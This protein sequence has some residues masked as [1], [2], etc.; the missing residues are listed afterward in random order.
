MG[1]RG[2]DP[3]SIRTDHSRPLLHS[4]S[5]GMRMTAQLGAR[6]RLIVFC[7]IAALAAHAPLRADN[8]TAGAVQQATAVSPAPPAGT[9]PGPKVKFEQRQTV[10]GDR[11][12]QRLGMQLNVTTKIVQSGQV[13]HQSANEIRSQQQRT[14]DVLEAV[15]GRAVKARVLFDVAR[16]QTPDSETPTELVASPTQGKS[17]LVTRQ[18][19]KLVVTDADGAIPPLAEFTL[20]SEAL[21]GVGRPNPL[22]VVLAG[23]EVAIGQ[24]M[25]VPRDL[26]KSLLGLGGP[27]LADVHKFELT[28]DRLAAPAEAGAPP[29]AVFRVTIEVKP[30]DAGGLAVI[31][32][33]EMAVEPTTCRLTSVDLAGPVHVSTIERTELGFYQYAMDGELRVATRAQFGSATK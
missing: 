11:V 25:F 6:P 13:A 27:E 23:R 22:A 8:T 3:K 5:G 15:D 30:D 14:V 28:L 9:L 26:A 32:N 24:R 21:E 17:Y 29:V 20:V 10:V 4:F 12:V 7:L 19:D 18:D 2:L 16:R 31:L 33:G 1:G